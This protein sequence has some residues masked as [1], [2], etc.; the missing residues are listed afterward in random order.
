MAFIHQFAQLRNFVVFF[1]TVV[2]AYLSKVVNSFC[3]SENML[4][5][6]KQ[7]E[8]G[9]LSF[10]LIYVRN[11]LYQLEWVRVTCLALQYFDRVAALF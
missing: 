2:L 4:G 6:L 8:D 3:F 5:S 1:K 10:D 9:I 11:F 7:V